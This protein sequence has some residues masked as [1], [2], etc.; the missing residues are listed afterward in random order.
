MKALCE[1]V[2]NGQAFSALDPALIALDIREKLTLA[3]R[4]FE[5]A[6]GGCFALGE[7]GRR[8]EIALEME[9]HEQDAGRRRAAL[10][11]ALA[12]AWRGGWLETPARPGLR[13]HVALTG[14]DEISQTR[15]TQRFCLRFA[16]EPFADWE[17]AE[18]AVYSLSGRECES[19][20]RVAGSCAPARVA[21]FAAAPEGLDELQLTLDGEKLR[22]SGLSLPAGHC[23]SVLTAED[24]GRLIVRDDT[25][26]RSCLACLTAES[27]LPAP[28]PGRRSLK[29][30]A[31]APVNARLEVRGRYV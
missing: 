26:G 12:W 17:V 4:E 3:R 15:W 14:M 24:T 11:G 2:L 1:A 16:A 5:P 21:L 29:L 27:A 23:L 22:L 30:S 9:A 6:C 25:A 10:D 13:L 7:P 18:P 31:D 8:R 20:I 28:M 19:E